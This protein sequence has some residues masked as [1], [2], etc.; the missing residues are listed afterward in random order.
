MHATLTLFRIRLFSCF[1]LFVLSSSFSVFGQTGQ[2]LS[3]GCSTGVAFGTTQSTTSTTFVSSVA[4]T[5]GGEFNTYN[6]TA[7]QTYEWSL[8]PT[9]G[10]T[11][12]TNTDS[13]LSLRRNDN[14]AALCYSDDFCGA[15]AKILWTATFTG[16]VRVYI[17]RWS[18]SSLSSSHTVRW[19]C[20]SCGGGGGGSYNPCASIPAISGCSVQTGI[21]STTGTGAW[22][23]Y[24]GPYS[25]PGQEKLFTFTPTTSGLHTVEILSFSG[26]WV[27]FFFKPTSGGC[28]SS[29]WT[30]IDDMIGTGLTASFNLTAGVPYYIMWDPEG[31]SSNS[32]NFRINCPSA[33]VYNPCTSIPTLS[34]G[35]ASNNVSASGTGA[36]NN[37]GGPYLVPGQ[38]KL[39]T[40]TPPTSGNYQLEVL[41]LSGGWVDFFFKPTSGGCNSSGWTFVGDIIS[42]GVLP[43]VNLTGGVPYYFMWDPEGT[44]SYS[45]NFR[46][47]CA[48]PNPTLV[49]AT[50]NPI[51]SGQSTTLTASGA[52]GTVYW[53]T[54]SC[55]SSG[56]IGTGNSITVSPTTTTTYFARNFNNGQFS[57]GCASLTVTVNAVPAPTVSAGGTTTFCQGGSVSLTSSGGSN[58]IWNNGSSGSSI[59]ATTTGN[60]SAQAI[61]GACTSAVS[62]VISVTVNANPTPPTISAAG[63]TTFCQGANVVLNSS[64]SSG[65]GWSGGLG[66]ANTST[67]TTSGNY[68]ATYTD[69]NGCTSVSSNVIAVTVNPTPPAPVVTAAGPTT[70]CQGGNVVLNSSYS[71]GNGWSGGLG[72]ASTATATSTDN[73]TATYTDANGCTSSVSNVISVTVN[74]TPAAP[75]ISPS[76][77][78]AV[79][80]GSS[81][82]LSSSYSAG[83]V[84][85]TGASGS[86][87]LVSNAGSYTVIHTDANGC[88]SPA[89]AVVSVTVNPLP[90]A[91]Q[92]SVGGPTLFCAGNAVALTSSYSSGNT[93]N[94][95]ATGDVLTA[96]QTGA[97]LVTHTDANGC[98]SANST[99]VLVTVN[100]LPASP[101]LSASG[102][103]T[104]CSGDSVQLSANYSSGLAW[105]TGATSAVLTA[106]VQDTYSATYTDGNGCTSTPS[107]GVAVTV[108]PNPVAGVLTVSTVC[109]GQLTQFQQN[110]SVSN[111]NGSVISQY[112]WTLGDGNSTPA[113]TP[114]HTYGVAGAYPVQLQVTTNYGCVDISSSQALVQPRPQILSA[115][116]GTV[117]E[118]VSL[119]FNQTSQI[120][121]VNGALLSQYTWFYGDGNTSQGSNASYL[122][123]AAGTYNASLVV[124]S[125]HGCSDTFSFVSVV[126]PVPQVNNIQSTAVC[127]GNMSQINQL[128]TVS[129]VNGAQLGS[130]QWNLGDGN[131]ANG[132]SVAHTYGAAGAYIVQLVVGTNQGCS[133]TAL[134]TVFVHPNPVISQLS[135]P[136]VCFG[137]AT[138]LGQTSQVANI[139]G[140][141][142][143][144]HAWTLGDGNQSSQS[145][146]NH[147]YMAEGSYPVTYVVTT[148]QGCTAT[149]TGLAFVNPNPQIQVVSGGTVCE[150]SPLTFS[151]LS[152]VS[153]VNG[154][155]LVSFDWDYGDGNVG[156]GSASS[157]SYN[158]AGTFPVLLQVQTNHGCS[159][160]SSTTAVVNPVPVLSNFTGGD[161]CEGGT[162]QFQTQLSLSNTNGA[163]MQS[164]VWNFGDGSSNSSG[165]VQVQHQYSQAGSYG[166]W[167]LAQTNQGCSDT[168][169]HQAFV[170]EV[171][172]VTQLQSTASCEGQSNVFSAQGSVLGINNAQVSNVNWDFGDGNTGSGSNVQHVYAGW[173][174]YTYTATVSTQFGCSA[175]QNGVVQVHASPVSDFISPVHC[176]GE[177]AQFTNL[178]GIVQGLVVSYFWDFGDFGGNSTMLNPAYLYTQPGTYQV[179]LESVSDM[180]CRDTVV[181]AL[182]VLSAPSTQFS[183]QLSGPFTVQFTPQL[184]DPTLSYQWDFG[185]GSSSTQMQPGKTYSQPGGYTVCLRV[186]SADCSNETCSFFQLNT[187]GGLDEL[188]SDK[189]GL[190][191]YPNP[192][193]GPGTLRVTLVQSEKVGYGLRDVSGRL[194]H[195]VLPEETSSGTHAYDMQTWLTSLP[196]GVYLLEVQIGDETQVIRWVKAPGH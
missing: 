166:L 167:I 74:S 151:Q 41:G 76:G 49:S 176:Y 57:P 13:Q 55:G 78:V 191:V 121:S 118:G 36:W 137:Q 149:S 42:P 61:S 175:S 71:S 22:N 58:F 31:T 67:V 155:Q 104:F 7:G 32:V 38:E 158:G 8:C 34:C 138:S 94:T 185:D 2:C 134:S 132:L 44:G 77:T 25:V 106:Q 161:V 1:L 153:N 103:T 165:N 145:V 47:N 99:P 97:Y 10:A 48:P 170:H 11:V 172:V 183:A 59:T 178:S 92:V 33:P 93:W 196:A 109:E 68:S 120:A 195:Q 124:Q 29:G 115:Q 60:Y 194:L 152:S 91:P 89:S 72:N 107:L 129:G 160:I 95:G 190:S 87:E 143:A 46:V 131:T 180:G 164:L 148:N 113:S 19:R 86:N 154:A 188:G 65:N 14:N 54:G 105:S 102:P 28:N 169:F 51:C 108:N 136:A 177:E 70:F 174:S 81:I 130:Y 159:V 139:N 12:G 50:A 100:A 133:D 162:H 15:H 88:V 73:Y 128:S 6:V 5:W 187:M 80:Q 9:D 64:Y 147:N 141:S 53:F 24:G 112:Q 45:V 21:V 157:H 63:P 110:A 189:A 20:V 126:N 18:C 66:N 17:H 192:S 40:F 3:G 82:Q 62:N 135:V 163:S 98:T 83:N 37:Y 182:T 140:A 142:I 125:N 184:Q 52:S 69:G 30:F 168:L 193:Q 79:C 4:G 27:D 179:S 146:L 90:S 26:S 39:F 117:C 85:S 186:S 171:P 150:G 111:Q 84:W 156:Q 56:Q 16:V 101:V 122:Y 119:N 75:V 127:D 181:Y 43:T 114:S 23:F 96:T 123:S 173:G 144:Q 35:V 116:S